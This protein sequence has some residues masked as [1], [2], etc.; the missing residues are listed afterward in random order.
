[1]KSS[2]SMLAL[3]A[4]AVT[5]ATPAHAQNYPWCAIYSGAPR[6]E[7]RIVVLSATSSAWRRPAAWAAFV[8]GTHNSCRRPAPI[9][10]CATIR[11]DGFAAA[12]KYRLQAQDYQ[13][14]ASAG[15]ASSKTSARGDT[16]STTPHQLQSKLGNT[17]PR[18]SFEA[19]RLD[20]ICKPQNGQ[21]GCGALASMRPTM[22]L[23][24]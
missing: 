16:L 15:E 12:E 10:N 18:L 3:V 21:C 2:L 22:G 9:R 1:M 6:A 19:V 14:G 24:G 23:H 13:T 7:E 4:A 5:L 20:C 17:E 8:T 11:T